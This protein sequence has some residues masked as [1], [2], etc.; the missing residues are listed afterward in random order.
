MWHHFFKIGIYYSALLRVLSDD[1]ARRNQPCQLTSSSWFPLKRTRWSLEDLL[2]IM[3]LARIRI[4]MLRERK[5]GEQNRNEGSDKPR[6]DEE[7]QT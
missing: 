6:K 2:K 5:G 4:V 3:C 1:S 7:Q